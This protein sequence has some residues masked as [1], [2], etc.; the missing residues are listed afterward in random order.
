MASA[1]ESSL[2]V[3]WRELEQLCSCISLISLLTIFGSSSLLMAQDSASQY[4]QQK[5]QAMAGKLYPPALFGKLDSLEKQARDAR[6]PAQSEYLRQQARWLLPETPT[7]PEHVSRVM[8]NLKFK[9]DQY[10]VS[11]VYATNG[12][13]VF[14][15]SRDGTLRQWNLQNGRT[16]KTWDL[17]NPL[18]H[19]VLSPD[20][21]LLAVAEGYRLTP[22]L[23]VSTLPIQDDYAI[24]VIDIASG[25]IK[26]KLT[27][28]KAAIH[29][30]SFSSDSKLLVSGSQTGKSDP[31]RVWNVETGKFERGIKVIHAI[32][33]IAWSN[34]SSKLYCSTSDKT[35]AVFDSK[36]GL[37][38]LAMPREKGTIYAMALNPDQSQLAL[39]GDVVEEGSGLA[40]KIYSTKDWKLV[41]TLLGHQASV[42]S[43]S[44]VRE[45]KLLVSASAKPEAAVKVWDI[46]QKTAVSQYQGH[47]NDVLDLAMTNT[48]QSI[49]TVSLDGSIRLWQT[50]QVKPAALLFQGKSPVWALA[51]HG[52]LLLAAG[53]DQ[54]A[55]LWD[56]EASKEL[57]RF[58][59]HQ[60]PVT[61][62]CFRPDGAEVATG[63]GD[64]VIRL[65]DPSTGKATVTLPGHTGVITAL[66]YSPDGRRLYSA[67]A[68]KTIRIW[69]VG[70][71]KTLHT[72]PQHRSV[73][74]SLAVNMQG[75]LLATGGA[76]NLIRVW[77]THDASEL[78]TLIGHTG[79]ITG[80]AF[81]PGGTLLAS[82]GADG[83]T[84]LWDP[85]TRGDAMR[86]LAGHTGQLMAVAFSPNNR[87]LATAGAD[88]TI[89][90]WNLTNGSEA[91]ALQGHTDWIT[92]L[93]YLSDGDTLVSASV[94]GSVKIWQESK[95]F[96]PLVFGHEHPIRYLAMSPPGD[97]LASGSEEGKII[98]WD[99]ATGNPMTTLTSHVFSIKGL[100][101]SSDGKQLLSADKDQYLKLWDVAG[102]RELQSFQPKADSI[103]RVGFLPRDRGILASVGSSNM[104]A[105]SFEDK[106]IKPEP[107]LSFLGYTNHCNAVSFAQDRIAMGG[108]D[109][110]VKFWKL[111]D[112]KYETDSQLRAYNVA[113]LELAISSD[114]K[115][116]LT[117]NQENEYKLWNMDDKKLLKNWVA[118]PVRLQAIALHPTGNRILAAFETGEVVLWDSDGR[119]MR[120]WK[121]KTAMNDVIFSPSNSNAYAGSAHGVIYQLD[122]P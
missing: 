44:F 57:H 59:E 71:K 83:V 82:V 97:R 117:A 68:D 88:E 54:T 74:T 2:K 100:G 80:L 7:L 108:T 38:V 118:R 50:S 101:F 113:V 122:L 76:D 26:W 33:N 43:L 19:L 81:S 103:N 25:S 78:R 61:A 94:D 73:V 41:Q 87:F 86:T 42:T 3:V 34:D 51:S 109:G 16:L 1:T 107:A 84:K 9:H 40:I 35:L 72:L 115:R 98:V 120:S 95:A 52:K 70:E 24:H 58:T 47:S 6:Q 39:A 112:F 96:E 92:S 65:W 55:H 91:R 27:G 114:G 15:S 53:A 17:H 28:T 14:T 23:D 75:S 93:T 105:W 67:S 79:A 11:V 10:P 85:A 13:S 104:L 89:R 111:S 5:S 60:S 116:L 29:C 36:S 18:G 30:L 49:V 45:G 102:S 48:G 20:G 69:D 37:Q 90:I 12:E 32:L 121:F 46:N 8:G 56:M 99:T 4:E 66:A 63:G 77:R 110:M 106:L 64:F 62:G 21:K 119:E 31:I 22:N